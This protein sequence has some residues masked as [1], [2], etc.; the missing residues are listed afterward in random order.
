VKT[1]RV[2]RTAEHAREAILEVAEQQ[3]R[4]RG[5]AALRLQDVAAAAGMSHPTVLHHFGSREVL[6]A[7]VVERAA[8]ALQQDLVTAFAGAGPDGAAMIEQVADV[9]ATRGHGR[10]IAWL[11]LSGYN[12]VDARPLEQGWQ[13]VARRLHAARATGKSRRSAGFEDTQF[14]LLL[15]WLALFGQ[16]VAGPAMFETAGLGGDAATAKRFRAWLAKLIAQ[17]LTVT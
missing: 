6:V 12:P 14:V 16:A 8:L 15:S 3:L 11:L 4:D 9:F 1:R 10:L 2:R 13:A 17:H 7:A 5:P